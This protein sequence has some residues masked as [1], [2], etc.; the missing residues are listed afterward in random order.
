V[1]RRR[2]RSKGA[3]RAGLLLVVALLAGA[4]GFIAAYVLQEYRAERKS[5]VRE[6]PRAA[7]GGPKAPRAAAPGSRRGSAGRP[8]EPARPGVGAVAP[9]EESPSGA[10]L[11]LVI[12]DF[13]GNLRRAQ[14]F[15][16]LEVP[17]TPAILPYLPASLEVAH[18]ARERGRPFLVHLPMEPAGYPRVNPGRGALLRTMSE[19]EVR[20]SVR[21]ALASLP[22]A[23]GVNNHMGSRL[24]ELREPMDW[25]MGVLRTNS[26][27]FLDS[28]TSARSV[29]GTAAR[30]AGLDWI[31][32]DV[33]LDNE[34][35]VDAIGVQLDLA[36]E[37]AKQNGTAVAIGHP[38]PVTLEAI[39][40]WIPR[41][42]EAEVEVVPIDA[43]LLRPAG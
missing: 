33:F 17:I 26:L 10:R 1:S 37:R 25:L 19:E 16:E 14:E 22:G 4:V 9:L 41:M 3:G 21:E 32:R 15:L 13:G 2:P 34:E 23:A 31:R 24:T 18:L 11:A 5:S 12:D 6:R 38:Y 8:P 27:F 36:L 30:D 20:R 40:R 29:A 43:L 7:L 42:K 35:D 28:R 39:K